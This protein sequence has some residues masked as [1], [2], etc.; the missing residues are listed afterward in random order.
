MNN[1]NLR[2]ILNDYERKRIYEINALEARKNELYIQVP[3]L[4]QIDTELSS[5]S[6][7]VAKNLIKYNNPALMDTL[8]Q[9]INNLS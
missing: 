4:K 5:T 2:T 3:R 8:K 6:I 7:S 1:V 9:N